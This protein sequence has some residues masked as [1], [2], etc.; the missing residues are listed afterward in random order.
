MANLRLVFLACFVQFAYCAISVDDYN[1][2]TRDE[3][4]AVRNRCVSLSGVAENLISEIKNGSF[5]KE[6]A[7]KEYVACFWLRSGMIDRNFELN[8]AKFDQFVTSVVDDRVAD[9][10]KHCHKMSK[11]LG[12]KV[13][14][15]DKIW[16]MIQCDYFI[17]SE[18][19]VM[20]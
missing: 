3:I 7:I 5:R 10:Y 12:K 15:V 1:S 14:L 4:L 6:T 16:V 18:K 19:F 8:Q 17:S 2:E 13:T 9:M 11:S 20:F